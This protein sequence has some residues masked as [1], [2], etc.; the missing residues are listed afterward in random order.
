MRTP[1]FIVNMPGDNSAVI[2]S[3][4]HDELMQFAQTCNCENCDSVFQSFNQARFCGVNCMKAKMGEIER[5]SCDMLIKCLGWSTGAAEWAF[6]K[7]PYK[8]YWIVPTSKAYSFH[9]SETHKQHMVIALK[10]RIHAARRVA[11]K[12]LS[13]PEREPVCV[14]FVLDK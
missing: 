2:D 1:Y 11:K 3:L 7:K 13:A 14:I 6:D 5:I 10:L 9:M 8:P 12:R 4:A